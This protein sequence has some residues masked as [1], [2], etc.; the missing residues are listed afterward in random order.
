MT[1][2]IALRIS[3][4]LAASVDRLCVVD[5]GLKSRS[6]FLRTAIEK[7]V[8]ERNRALV[9]AQIIAGYLAKSADQTVDEWGDL[10]AQ[11]DLLNAENAKAL[12]AQDGGW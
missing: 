3:E 6:E 5:G 9:D 4:E 7:H 10:G 2:Q 12:D 8:A 11:H 1:V